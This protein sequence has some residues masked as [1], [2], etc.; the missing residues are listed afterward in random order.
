LAREI[1]GVQGQI[2]TLDPEYSGGTEVSG[3]LRTSSDIK[4]LTLKNFLAALPIFQ[5][6]LRCHPNQRIDDKKPLV[7]VV[8][9]KFNFRSVRRLRYH[10]C[11][12]NWWGQHR[13]AACVARRND[14]APP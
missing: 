8:K 10:H 6:Y 11:T 1:G 12:S 4:K 2:L 9:S 3:H 14:C 7:V 5:T 13:S